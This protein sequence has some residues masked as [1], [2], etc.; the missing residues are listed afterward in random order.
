MEENMIKCAILVSVVKASAELEEA[1]RSLDELE[2]LLDTAG[3][4][5][6]ARVVQVKATFPGWKRK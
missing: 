1:E 4:E 5:A 3:G 6:I 2:R